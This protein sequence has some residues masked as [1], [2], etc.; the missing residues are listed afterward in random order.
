MSFQGGLALRHVFNRSAKHVRQR[1]I[2]SVLRTIAV[3]YN[4]TIAATADQRFYHGSPLMARQAAAPT[5]LDETTA[6]DPSIVKSAFRNHL[7]HERQRAM[8]GGGQKRIDRQ[9]ARGKLAARERL[10]LL[11]DEGTFFELDQLKAHR[12]T[13]FGMG[14]DKHQIPG[15]GIVT[16][17]G[18]VNG[19]I[20][21][22][23][24]QDFTVF[25]GSLSETH[26]QK[27]VKI[28]DMAMRVG[29]PVIG[30]NDS[31]GARIQ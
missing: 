31:G 2:S 29:A 24:S 21:Y 20:V 22:A 27:M 7:E 10:E 9:H 6:S 14:K 18:L 13:E 25:G 23:F 5:V 11:F 26:A 16:G 8:L 17:H 15:D 19:R 28:M 3:N 4:G 30:L 12:C 1:H